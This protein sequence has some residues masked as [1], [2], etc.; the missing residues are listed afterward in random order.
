MSDWII[1]LIGRYIAVVLGLI[2]LKALGWFGLAAL[3]WGSIFAIGLAPV[4]L[5]VLFF[6]IF[7][8]AGLIEVIVDNAKESH[9]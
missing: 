1:Q 3:T 2:I 9:R 6:L 4:V 7:V 5:S 8:A